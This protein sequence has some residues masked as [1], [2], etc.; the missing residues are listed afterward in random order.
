MANSVDLN[1]AIVEFSEWSRP[2]RFEPS[3]SSRLTPELKRHFAE[4]IR[5]SSKPSR[6]VDS[7]IMSSCKEIEE[8]L[9][10]EFPELQEEAISAVVR[11]VSYQWR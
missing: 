5:V 1:K 8:L 2:W 10:E 7:D 6:W 9:Q 11:A 4:I 3:V